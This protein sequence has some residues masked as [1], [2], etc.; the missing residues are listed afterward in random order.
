[1]V[2]RLSGA[3]WTKLPDYPFM[4][5]ADINDSQFRIFK[6]AMTHGWFGMDGCLDIGLND[7]IVV[8]GLNVYD[9]A[10]QITKTGRLFAAS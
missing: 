5:S 2:D 10:S 4:Q 8:D 6:Q 7:P 1:M 9:S 3:G